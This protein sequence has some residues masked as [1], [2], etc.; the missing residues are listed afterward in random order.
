MKTS[1]FSTSA[2]LFLS[3]VLI[4]NSARGEDA[5]G[6]QHLDKAVEIQ[7]NA[8]TPKELGGVIE[9]CR[10]ALQ[11][12]LDD[13][14]ALF[15]KEML[16]STLSRRASAVQ[17]A[18]TS[19]A[20][21]GPVPKQ[22]YQQLRE[23][24]LTDIREAVKV[25]P[26]KASAHYLLGRI[27]SLPGGSRDEA[28]QAFDDAVTHAKDDALKAQA[29][30]ARGVLQKDVAK[31][32]AD[33]GAA[34]KLVP[35]S[36]E[37][38]RTRGAL[39]LQ[40]GKLKEAVADLTKA[41]ELAPNHA[42][43]REMLALALARNGSVPD[44]IKSLT[45]AIKDHPKN[46]GL[47]LQRARML[48]TDKKLDDAVQDMDRILALRPGHLVTLLIRAQAHAQLGHYEAAMKDAQAVLDAKPQ[49]VTALQLRAS[50]LVHGKKL[51]EAAA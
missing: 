5:K 37:A 11:K 26:K 41:A 7:L 27:L 44:A 51:A 38:L 9:Q 23:L 39:Y 4:S 18:I 19:L 36:A 25:L 35:D 50:L 21:R 14:N 13:D 3:V 30:T 34:I 31:M 6:L 48:L 1:T 24:A 12:G 49:A 29:L 15:A 16:V 40:T 22:Q 47:L 42:R 10:L 17:G 43:S 8:R 45:E 46:P 2:A 32:L 20:Q 28:F 33:H